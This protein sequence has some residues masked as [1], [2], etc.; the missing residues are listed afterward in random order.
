MV[1]ITMKTI[2]SMLSLSGIEIWRRIVGM[3]AGISSFS[4][5]SSLY[6]FSSLFFR[7]KSVWTILPKLPPNYLK[8][9]FGSYCVFVPSLPNWLFCPTFSNDFVLN[10]SFILSPVFTIHSVSFTIKHTFA[11][12]K[13]YK[14]CK[15]MGI[16]MQFDS[17]Q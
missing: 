11:S 6:L 15:A 10:P 7:P 13:S 8:T 9:E 12:I 1:K 14:S 5:S 2:G 17:H 16:N 3:L 4:S